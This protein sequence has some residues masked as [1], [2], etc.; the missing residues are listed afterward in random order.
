MV[1][2][3]ED[4]MVV[5]TGGPGRHSAVIPTFG[6]TKAVTVPITDPEGNPI[7]VNSDREEH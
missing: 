6:T 2:S 5:V 3:P 1:D 7:L 4:L